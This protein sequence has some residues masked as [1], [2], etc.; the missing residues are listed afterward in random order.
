M[1]QGSIILLHMIFW[2]TDEQSRI[3]KVDLITN[4]AFLKIMQRYYRP[5]ELWVYIYTLSHHV[6]RLI[7]WQTQSLH[8]LYHFYHIDGNTLATFETYF[9]R[10][11]D[12]LT[13]RAY[14]SFENEQQQQKQQQ[15]TVID[16]QIPASASVE[17]YIH[18]LGDY[19]RIVSHPH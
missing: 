13:E 19:A 12:T 8:D 18:Q 7:T 5:A 2:G 17:K 6:L 14:C 16:K 9:S 11:P 3:A 4:L 15:Q 10:F 1:Y